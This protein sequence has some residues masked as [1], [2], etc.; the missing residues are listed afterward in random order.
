MM[1]AEKALG[2]AHAVVRETQRGAELSCAT[3][4]RGDAR[5]EPQL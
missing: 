1:R 2:L 3:G 5:D 4:P